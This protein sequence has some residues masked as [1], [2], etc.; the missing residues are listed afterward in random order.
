MFAD[1]ALL[2]PQQRVSATGRSAIIYSCCHAASGSFAAALLE[3]PPG[4]EQLQAWSSGGAQA[5]HGS[6]ALTRA[7]RGMG[8]ERAA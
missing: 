5:V 1:A 4:S 6:A 2:L 7:R 8:V 3:L